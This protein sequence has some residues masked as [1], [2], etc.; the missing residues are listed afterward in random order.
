[1]SCIYEMYTCIYAHI[2]YT[3]DIGLINELMWG[4]ITKIIMRWML[5]VWDACVSFLIPPSME[6]ELSV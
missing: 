1:M 6:S 3:Y 4:R 5:L 2:I